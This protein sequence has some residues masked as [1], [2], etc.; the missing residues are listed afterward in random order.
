[1]TGAAD[2]ITPQMLL[3]A[4]AGGYFPMAE[5]RE[6]DELF[7]FHPQKRGI[8]PLESFHVPHSLEKA[9]KRTPFILTC[10]KAFDGV[11]RACA[12]PNADRPETW[13]NDRIIALY[14]ALHRMGH[15]HSIE[16]W[17]NGTL[18]GGLYG[19]AIGGAFFGESMFSR[20]SNA[21]KAALVELVT[22][23]KAAGYGLLDTQYV[24]PHL[25]QFGCIE[26][27][28]GNY[29]NM[30]GKALELHPSPAFSW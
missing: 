8:I 15:A 29:M 21:S 4:Y 12:E 20:A 9:L 3:T 5:S 27:K 10:N 16:C 1:M 24:N 28:R 17:Q 11:I 2:E 14:S 19:V 13:I 30:L 25:L 26:V 7:W 18:A 23:L 6:A 22:R